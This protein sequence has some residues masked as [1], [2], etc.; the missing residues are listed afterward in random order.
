M[1]QVALDLAEN[2]RFSFHCY[3]DAGPFAAAK[4]PDSS[5]RIVKWSREG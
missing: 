1:K 2:T 4:P 5:K 3:S